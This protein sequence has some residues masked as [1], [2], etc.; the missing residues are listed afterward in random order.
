MVNLQSYF[1]RFATSH[2]DK[3]MASLLPG[4]WQVPQVFRDRLGEQAGRQRAMFH[5]GHLLLVLHKPPGPED[6]ERQGRFFWRQPDGTW[7]SNELGGGPGALAK[8]L[9][10]YSTLVEKLEKQ[11]DAATGA[12]DYFAVLQAISPIH[13]AARNMHHVL[14]EARQHCPEDRNLIAFRDEAYAIERMAELLYDGVKNA[15]DFAVAR[16]AEELA[17]SSHQMSVSA[18]RLNVLAAFF[19]PIATLMAIF[20]T[21]LQHG[22]ETMVPPIPFLIV[23][24]IGLFAGCVMTLFIAQRGKR[25]HPSRAGDVQV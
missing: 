24:G 21:N 20:G 6:D 16:R 22:L 18:H 2:T 1:L 17:K 9:E 11:E 19:F 3:A 10:D 5:E 14:Q 8:H 13:R 23:L 4:V 7:S 15:L 25:N 12:E